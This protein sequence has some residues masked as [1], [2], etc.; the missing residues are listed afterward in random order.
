[1][2]TYYVLCSTRR[3]YSYMPLYWPQWYYTLIYFSTRASSFMSALW[4]SFDS[5]EHV[6]MDCLG[7]ILEK[8]SW[9]HCQ[10]SL[11]YLFLLHQSIRK[12]FVT[13]KDK[14]T[15]EQLRLTVHFFGEARQRI[16]LKPTHNHCHHCCRR[17]G[18]CCCLHC[19]NVLLMLNGPSEEVARDTLLWLYRVLVTTV[20][21]SGSHFIPAILNVYL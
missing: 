10:Y 4:L 17:C 20:L 8:N 21:D 11:S 3:D 2:E 14:I 18:Y 19:L 9:W 12:I 6:L 16:Y 13:K 5:G 1:M 15:G 7:L